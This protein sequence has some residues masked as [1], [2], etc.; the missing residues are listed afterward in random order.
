M[1]LHFCILLEMLAWMNILLNDRLKSLLLPGLFQG[2][3]LISS[4]L[5]RQFD[6]SL[7]K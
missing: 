2:E 5:R 6:R 1:K 4:D 7:S 3:L